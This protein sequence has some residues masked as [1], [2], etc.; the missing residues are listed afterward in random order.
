MLIQER[1]WA[2]VRKGGPDECWEWVGATKQGGYGLFGKS[3]VTNTSSRLAHR[4]SFEIS[5]GK[6]PKHICVLHRCDNPPCV[7]PNHLF[8]GSHRDNTQDMIE[9]GRWRGG[10]KPR[11][12]AHPNSKLTEQNVFDI[13]YR[14]SIGEPVRAIAKIYGVSFGLISHIKRGR[15]WSYLNQPDA[16]LPA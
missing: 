14:L 2:K 8:L 13:K 6:I 12:Q 7:N 11:G 10:I 4:V 5:N 15:A 16:K 9:K 1:F 3:N